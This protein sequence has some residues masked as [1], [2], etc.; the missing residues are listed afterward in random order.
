MASVTIERTASTFQTCP[1]NSIYPILKPKSELRKYKNFCIVD[2]PSKQSWL[3]IHPSEAVMLALFDGRFSQ[4]QIGEVWAYIYNKPVEDG[5]EMTDACV[6]KFSKYLDFR[7]EPFEFPLHRYNPKDF[8]YKINDESV[9]QRIVADPLSGECFPIPIQISISVTQHCNFR[10]EYCYTTP[11]GV[12][13]SPKETTKF[14]D[15]PK[16]LSL[17]EEAA[18]FGTIFVLITGGEPAL[19]KGWMDVILKILELN[20][21]PVL[22]TNGSVITRQQLETLAAAGLP[23]ITF[24]LDAPSPDL[25]HKITQTHNTFDRVITAIQNSVDVGLHTLVKCVLTTS[26][27]EV[28]PEFI[29]FIVGIG[30]HE[31][32]I[33]Y[34]EPGD[35]NSC[36]T[37]LS[38]SHI[39]DEYKCLGLCLGDNAKL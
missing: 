21:I 9:Y 24:S 15:L 25:H 38:A 8:I 12:D 18:E 28:I 37:K 34:M 11:I 30:V 2:S 4:N 33:T 29:D 17:L 36:A 3:P 13:G 5:L 35:R 31:L 20:M 32:A 39:C 26:N 6:K 16:V 27:Y 19:F 10:C 22:T 1:V 14:L 23:E 7:S